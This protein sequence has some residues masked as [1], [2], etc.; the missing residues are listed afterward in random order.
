MYA[1]GGDP[2]GRS[3]IVTVPGI[4]ADEATRR[5]HAEFCAP[6]VAVTVAV[7]GAAESFA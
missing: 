7:V 4:H 2:A 5:L 6:A 1:V 3:L